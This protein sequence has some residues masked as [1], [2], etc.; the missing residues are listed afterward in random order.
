L[1]GGAIDRLLITSTIDARRIQ[2]KRAHGK[3]GLSDVIR[4]DRRAIVPGPKGPSAVP[5]LRGFEVVPRQK[6]R[7]EACQHSPTQRDRPAVMC[8]IA[9]TVS[10][11]LWDCRAWQ[12]SVR[13]RDE[14]TSPVRGFLRGTTRSAFKLRAARTGDAGRRPPVT[15]RCEDRPLML[16]YA[17]ASARPWPTRDVDA[18]GDIRGRIATVRDADAPR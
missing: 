8:A 14:T 5:H 9:E 2:F 15:Q 4:A 3:G 10:R 7:L 16:G 12:G 1:T 17:A 18:S 13:R 11:I 6:W